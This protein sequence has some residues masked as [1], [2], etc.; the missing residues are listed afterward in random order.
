MD[1]FCQ[2]GY[3][4]GSG[5]PIRIRW[6]NWIRIRNTA[7]YCLHF[8][9]CLVFYLPDFKHLP[10]LHRGAVCDWSLALDCRRRKSRTSTGMMMTTFSPTFWISQVS[11]QAPTYN[12][13]CGSAL[14]SSES[15]FSILGWIPI[16]IQGIYDQ[17]LKKNYSWKKISIFLY[18]NQTTN[19]P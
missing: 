16:R 2:S 17:K 18:Q 13:G 8:L 9:E 7:F 6:P 10:V 14:I 12:Q 3:G 19:Y 5:I 11:K 15:G 4:S 1:I